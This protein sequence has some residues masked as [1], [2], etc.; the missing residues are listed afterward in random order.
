MFHQVFN[1]LSILLRKTVTRGIRYVTHRG[2][3]LHDGLDDTRQILIVRAPC[4]LC[5][6]LHIVHELLGILHG[7]HGALDDFLTVGVKLILD[8][9]VTRANTRM[10]TLALG[11]LQRLG[12]HVDILLYR[13]CQRTNGRPRNGL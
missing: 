6:E 8:V 2:T 1:L 7:S 11:I 3:G 13:A 4:I 5:V 10:D 12:G 9:G